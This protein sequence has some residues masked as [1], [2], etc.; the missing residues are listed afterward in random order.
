MSA[1]TV[2][3]FAAKLDRLNCNSSRPK[4]SFSSDDRYS[5][6]KSIC[7]T[8]CYSGSQSNKTGV[9]V[10]DTNRPT[11]IGRSSVGYQMSQKVNFGG[12]F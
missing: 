6:L 8:G 3:F 5:L 4:E 9:N 11:L 2:D 7:D 12:I 10:Y 1:F